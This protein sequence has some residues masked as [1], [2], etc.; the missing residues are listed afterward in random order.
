MPGVDFNGSFGYNIKNYQM[1]QKTKFGANVRGMQMGQ[2]NSLYSMDSSLFKLDNSFVSQNLFSTQSASN[3][4]NFNGVQYDNAFAMLNSVNAESQG[5]EVKGDSISDKLVDFAGKVGDFGK[6]TIDSVKSFFGKLVGKS[7]DKGKGNE[8]GKAL[9][10]INNAKDKEALTEALDGAKGEQVANAKKGE[11]SE[12]AQ[13]KS[14]KEAATAKKEAEN[15]EAKLEKDKTQ[16]DKDKSALEQA[17]SDVK[18]A[19]NGYAKAQQN[20]ASAE[21]NLSAA[22][23]AATPENPNTAAIQK[24]EAELN[25]AKQQEEVAQKQLED[26][27]QKETQAEQAVDKSTEQVNTS[28]AENQKAQEG[29]KATEQQL[30]TVEQ[31]TATIKDEGKQIDEGIEDGNK[32]LEQMNNNEAP[33]DSETV[34]AAADSSVVQTNQTIQSDQSQLVSLPSSDNPTIDFQNNTLNTEMDIKNLTPGQRKEVLDNY[35]KVNNLKPGESVSINGQI[36]AMDATGQVTIDGKASVSVDGKNDVRGYAASAADSTIRK[37][38]SANIQMKIDNMAAE[39]NEIKSKPN[40]TPED[41]NKMT[42]I[43]NTARNIAGFNSS[44][45]FNKFRA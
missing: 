45:N 41:K 20:T 32:K 40:L 5:G 9:D 28:E 35:N 29:L 22:K 25:T 12:K 8:V 2:M 24:A 13:K 16:L 23:A 21:Q 1:M 4:F 38:D 44:I 7:A 30:K 14:E 31:E 15:S 39:Y 42:Q 18:N 11:A 34:P 17:K 6:K 36:Y 19:E 43:M 33:S 3:N 10:D 26:A 37:N 27:K